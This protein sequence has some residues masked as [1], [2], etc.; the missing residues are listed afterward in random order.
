M[1][2]Q[3][4]ALWGGKEK[5]MR[6]EYEYGDSTYRAFQVIKRTEA[7]LGRLMTSSELQQLCNQIRA[8]FDKVSRNL[9]IYFPFR[10]G[11]IE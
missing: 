9:N 2:Q 7:R 6:Y 10:L 3:K 1:L 11:G 5:I 4:P 8:D